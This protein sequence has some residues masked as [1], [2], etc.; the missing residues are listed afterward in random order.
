RGTLDH[1]GGGGG[2]GA[3]GCA[4]RRALHALPLAPAAHLCGEDPLGHAQGLRRPSKAG[5]VMG[6]IPGVAS[7]VG[8]GGSGDVK[9]TVGR[10]IAARLDCPFRDADSFHPQANIE[11]MAGGHPLTDDDRWPWLRA[12]AAWI[13]EH[14]AAGT[15]G[16]VTCSALKRVYRDLVTG[17][18]RA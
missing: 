7:V 12:I 15:T 5:Q 10:L 2:G 3:G 8:M 1:H 9:P 11:K 18:Q 4:L 17:S 13:E 6:H 16:V 14:R